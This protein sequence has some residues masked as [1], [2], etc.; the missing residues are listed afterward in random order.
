MSNIVNTSAFSLNVQE[1]NHGMAPSQPNDSTMTPNTQDHPR[2]N[3]L[4]PPSLKHLGVW[5]YIAMAAAI[6][7]I[8]ASTFY[9]IYACCRPRR[10]VRATR[11]R[12]MNSESEVDA[13]VSHLVLPCLLLVNRV[14]R[15]F[16]SL[17][18]HALTP[19]LPMNPLNLLVSALLKSRA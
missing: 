15:W 5:A 7:C 6:C 16:Y 2:A 12:S 17:T 10:V 18:D 1:I 4:P 13:H 8:L 9:A 11:Q 19:H 14:S 3:P